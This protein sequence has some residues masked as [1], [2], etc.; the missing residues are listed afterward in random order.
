MMKKRILSVIIALLAMVGMA[1]AATD[2]GLT[3]CGVKITSANYNNI[4]YLIG[5]SGFSFDPQTATL[6]LDNVSLD[7][8]PLVDDDGLERP[9]IVF[10]ATY[11]QK[12]KLKLI[13]SNYLKGCPQG[14]LLRDNAC[15]YIDG[16]GS[17]EV[18]AEQHK[19]DGEVSPAL[20]INLWPNSSLYVRGVGQ[21]KLDKL[22]FANRETSLSLV[23]TSATFSQNVSGL[24]YLMLVSSKFEQSGIALK[25]G[26]IVYV[27]SGNEVTSPKV[28]AT[29][30]GDLNQDGA[31]NLYDFSKWM[32]AKLYNAGEDVSDY[33]INIDGLL[34]T[35]DLVMLGNLSGGTRR[36]GWRNI[37]MMH[38]INKDE[39]IM[40]G[41]MGHSFIYDSSNKTETWAFVDLNELDFDDNTAS[42][43]SCSS[44]DP[45]VATVSLTDITVWGNLP[46]KGFRVSVKKSGATN[47]TFG[48]ND[49]AGNEVK[50]TVPMSF[51]LQSDLLAS[52]DK[53]YGVKLNESAIENVALNTSMN[54]PVGT[55]M[56]LTIDKDLT[57]GYDL[58]TRKSR[59]ACTSWEVDGNDKVTL[60]KTSDGYVELYVGGGGSFTVTAKDGNNNQ[61]MASFAARDVYSYDSKAVYKNGETI[62]SVPEA[63]ISSIL[64]KAQIVE[65]KEMFT[66]NGHV[67]T[68]VNHYTNTV[69][70]SEVG[71]VSGTHFGNNTKETE[72]TIP[73]FAQL[74]RDG[75][76]IYE[77]ENTYFEDMASG[78]YPSDLT[79]VGYNYDPS[80]PWGGWG[81]FC[82]VAG[83]GST[84]DVTSQRL[85][86]FFAVLNV[87]NGNSASVVHLSTKPNDSDWESRPTNVAYKHNT[88]DIY[89]IGYLKRRRSSESWTHTIYCYARDWFF[90]QCDNSGNWIDGYGRSKNDNWTYR[91]Y[92][93][94]I[95][96]NKPVSVSGVKYYKSDKVGS[97]MEN[98]PRFEFSE[99]KDQLMSSVFDQQSDD[100]LEIEGTYSAARAGYETG[101]HL[102][103]ITSSSDSG[104]LY[105]WMDRKIYKFA[106]DFKS[107]D[108]FRTYENVASIAQVKVL[109]NTSGTSNQEEFIVLGSKGYKEGS[110]IMSALGEAPIA[111]DWLKGFDLMAY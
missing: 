73:V 79:V 106:N 34:T 92:A 48:Y 23:N 83:G 40:G 14:I 61:R 28:I 100:F 1:R 31:I 82:S 29:P 76:L 24:T 96:K 77:R 25:D 94:T 58:N 68:I 109:L 108:T 10:Y 54:V 78:P 12:F 66:F 30:G 18:S 9:A 41:P 91:P 88:G 38:E 102:G 33:D 19:V 16:P 27:T 50:I 63:K 17:L 5:N 6:T 55:T 89:C 39:Y 43:Y 64:G 97:V 13:G 49:K 84:D 72:Y 52:A 67:F 80:L 60:T 37:F 98:I 70:D 74:Y 85:S 86:I 42:H 47:I 90:F 32:D 4:N 53:I 71:S 107:Y 95:A 104:S 8:W 56:R 26:K 45:S 11:F 3:I 46:S 111:V 2:Y 93:L 62:F 44:S 15:V 21:L 51:F 75:V 110:V 57:Y 105:G 59:I 65:I 35:A 99:K 7:T 20:A 103:G 69:E 36:T 81:Y 101:K 87:D 22:L